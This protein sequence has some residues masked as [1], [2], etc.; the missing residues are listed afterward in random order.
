MVTDPSKSYILNN[1][2][3]VYFIVRDLDRRKIDSKAHKRLERSVGAEIKFV[4]ESHLAENGFFIVGEAE[5]RIFH[6]R[7]LIVH[8][9]FHTQMPGGEQGADSDHKARC[10][11]AFKF[12]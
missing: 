4:R 1:K 11:R 2:G 6:R 7:L 9:Q 5:K 12:R 10:R 3:G 8:F